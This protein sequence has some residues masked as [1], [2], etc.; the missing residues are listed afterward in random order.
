[1]SFDAPK[2]VVGGHVI[3]QAEIVKQPGQIVRET[4]VLSEPET[5]TAWFGQFGLGIARIGL[6]AGPLSQWL[7]EAR[8]RK[9]HNRA[10]RATD[11]PGFLLSSRPEDS[12]RAVQC[13]G[14]KWGICETRLGVIL[15]FQ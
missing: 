11:F 13:R 3:I 15:I 2:L 8:Y 10:V 14:L 9:E 5:L 6:E 7:P 1:M 12:R 4:K